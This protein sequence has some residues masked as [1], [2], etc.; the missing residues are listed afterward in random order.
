[1]KSYSEICSKFVRFS[2]KKIMDFFRLQANNIS[3]I[4]KAYSII[5]FK[6]YN[7]ETYINSLPNESKFWALVPSLLENRRNLKQNSEKLI[8]LCNIARLFAYNDP[9]IL[10]SSKISPYIT[11]IVDVAHNVQELRNELVSREAYYRDFLMDQMTINPYKSKIDETN[12]KI[13]SLKN[14]ATQL[15]AKLGE[16]NRYFSA[17]ALESE[18][19]RKRNVELEAFL[20]NLYD[21]H[22]DVEK[23]Y[24][25]ANGLLKKLETT[26]EGLGDV[27]QLQEEI[28][29]LRKEYEDM[30]LLEERGKEFR[31]FLIRTTYDI[32]KNDQELREEND[33]M[34]SEYVERV[35][36]ESV[37]AY[38]KSISEKK[39]FNKSIE[40]EWVRDIHVRHTEKLM[41]EI[42]Y[43]YRQCAWPLVRSLP[44]RNPVFKYIF[45]YSFILFTF[46]YIKQYENFFRNLIVN[47]KDIDYKIFNVYLEP[48]LQHEIKYQKYVQYATTMKYIRESKGPY[49]DFPEFKDP[50]FYRDYKRLS[51]L[52]Y[53][54][55]LRYNTR[56]PERKSM[57]CIIELFLRGT[58]GHTLSSPSS[59]IYTEELLPP[60]EQPSGA[61]AKLPISVSVPMASTSGTRKVKKS[62]EAIRKMYKR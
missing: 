16:L 22:T 26:R 46:R 58:V 1:M 55:D 60:S 5:S 52:Y 36:E 33:K 25:E 47:L 35:G 6:N 9:E 30:A 49:E 61:M 59:E 31:E 13:N 39:T 20:R 2:F 45:L 24:N 21:V 29:K 51:I 3:T 40:N 37:V 12:A 11:S 38:E 57:V 48:K 10:S 7:I 15:T 42:K 23:K 56:R 34:R 62:E 18:K 4:N 17:L 43:A 41:E 54:V 44:Y 8:E 14:N 19:L 53:P 28:K 50:A 32:M 27:E